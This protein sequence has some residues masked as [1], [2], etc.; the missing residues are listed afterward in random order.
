M[1]ARFLRREERSYAQSI[2]GKSLPLNDI[3]ITDEVGSSIGP[4]EPFASP[5]GAHKYCL[6]MGKDGY[7]SCLLIHTKAAFVHCLTHVWQR[8][9]TPTKYRINC[10]KGS[11]YQVGQPWHDYTPE[12]QAQL[13]ADWA[14]EGMLTG[15]PRA[16]YVSNHIRIGA[17]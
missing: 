2:F 4:V 5:T 1:K 17:A 11:T 15:D 16:S 14:S 7:A 9:F 8:R 3:L 12:Q 13:I 6:A 10:S